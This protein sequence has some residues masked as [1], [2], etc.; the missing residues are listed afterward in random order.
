MI[1]AGT[2][3]LAAGLIFLARRS[4]SAA[5][6]F[7]PLRN[8][9]F[10]NVHY[11][12]AGAGFAAL[13]PGAYAPAFQGILGPVIIFCLAWVGLYFGCGLEVRFHQRF[14]AGILL[15]NVI[16]PLIVFLVFMI[17]GIAYLQ[18]NGDTA[19]GLE[20][21]YLIALCCGFSLYRRHGIL[22]RSGQY[23]TIPALEDVLPAGHV[24]P[25]ILLAVAAF[26]WGGDHEFH[27]FGRVFSGAAPYFLTLTAIAVMAGMVLNM[28]IAGARS[29]TGMSAVLA[30]IA[31]VLGG[32]AFS[33]G[34]S[35]LF[36]GAGAGAFLINASLKRI[37][38]LDALNAGQGI[39]ERVFMF[40]F[41]ASVIPLFI[42][43][44]ARVGV[45]VGAAFLIFLVRALL[46]YG[47][48][49]AWM[50]RAPFRM[51]SNVL[52][53]T[54]LTGQGTLAAAAVMESSLRIPQHPTTI[55][56][57]AILLVLNQLAFGVSF[58]AEE[59]PVRRERRN[60]V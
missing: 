56:A 37:Q 43:G 21:F 2:L 18:L 51:R 57:L 23:P 35:S 14:S 41:G 48:I 58:L 50:A 27:V 11:L 16:Q 33:L 29:V 7:R 1:Y 17:A 20:Q 44:E 9:T 45:A 59:R 25:V 46:N 10:F 22:Y 47:L 28:L 5:A 40:F 42:S 30:G 24:L 32:L 39:V 3:L 31:A 60:H 6:L 15:N 55:A 36:L 53:W 19:A 52:L 38:L 8:L 54:G 49:G 13:F 4:G 34:F 12:L 26:L